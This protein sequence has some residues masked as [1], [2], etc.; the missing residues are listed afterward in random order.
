[1]IELEEFA[2]AVERMSP[3]KNVFGFADGTV[4]PICRPI[5]GQ[6]LVYN[7]HRRVQAIK[8]QSV[9]IPNGLIAHLHGP[10]EGRRHN[11]FLLRDSGLLEQLEMLSATNRCQRVLPPPP[12]H[13]KLIRRP[14][15][16]TSCRAECSPPRCKLDT[17]STRVQ[18]S[19]E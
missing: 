1:M 18:Q 3:M 5:V 15:V 14:S 17:W 11:A 6:H 2:V 19:S 8:F 16:F 9:V 12:P 4:R 7:G 10:C 13:P